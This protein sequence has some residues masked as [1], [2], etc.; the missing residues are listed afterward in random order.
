MHNILSILLTMS[1]GLRSVFTS[2]VLSYRFAMGIEFRESS[3]LI[4]SKSDVVAQKGMVFN[5]NVGFSELVNPD[6]K[7]SE[8][9]NYALYLGD[10]VLVS[11]VNFLTRSCNSGVLVNVHRVQTTVWK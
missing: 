10:T 4:S 2:D 6:A 8:G 11:E 9:K 3:L 7:T 1:C 5:I